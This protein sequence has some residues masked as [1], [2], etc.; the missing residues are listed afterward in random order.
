MA[1]ALQSRPAP[2]HLFRDVVIAGVSIS[3]GVT[4]GT[5]AV[6]DSAAT[7]VLGQ[8]A[9]LPAGIIWTGAMIVRNQRK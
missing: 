8:L 1:I 5:V 7:G 9:R 2:V 6:S 4:V 3:I